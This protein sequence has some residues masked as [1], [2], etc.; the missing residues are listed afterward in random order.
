MEEVRQ[1][2]FSIGASRAPE[3]DGL[4]AAFYQQFWDS[5]G[6]LV[7]AEVQR[8]FD[9]GEFP[10]DFN[11]TN[12]CLIPKIQPPTSMKDFRPIALCNVLYKIIS[13]IMVSRLKPFLTHVVSPNQAALIPRRQIQDNILLAHEVFHSLQV[14]KRCANSIMAVKTDI[15]KAYDRIEWSF[16]EKVLRLK[17]FCEKWISL[18]MKC[19]TSVSFS[20]MING[21]PYGRIQPSRGL[22][23]GDP[24]S[25]SLF[26]LTADVLSSIMAHAEATHRIVPLRISIGGPP[27]SH[28][29]LADDSLFFIKADHKNGDNLMKNFDAYERAS[30]QQINIEKSTITFGDN[31]FLHNR[32]AIQQILQISKI[33]GG[34]KYLGLP[35]QFTQRKKEIFSYL[36]KSV[37]SKIDGWQNKF[38]TTAGKEV[39]I[40][41]V[42]SAMPV[43]SMN[44]YKLPLEVCLEIESLLSKFWW[45][46]TN[47]KR[48]MSWMSWDRLTFAKQ[49]GGMGFKSL[50]FFNQALLANQ[51]WKLNL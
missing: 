25:L 18:I 24:L 14:R 12:L 46:S 37:L 41:S 40:K 16:L 17:G 31:V 10:V 43:F 22:R 44:S 51:V 47:E 29:L 27:V 20:V 36:K 45:G 39:L 33:G 48:K 42:A 7:T 4:T 19:V 5:L 11:H 3:P 6:P 49:Y 9:T 15:S 23:Q 30:G 2:V 28:L 21:S 13:K 26:I 50:A 35:E 34:G 8:F 1:S 38:L 32:N